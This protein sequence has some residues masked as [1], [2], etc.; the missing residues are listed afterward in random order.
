MRYYTT[1]EALEILEAEGITS[2]IQVLRRYLNKNSIPGAF[3]KSKKEGWSIPEEGLREFIVGKIGQDQMITKFIERSFIMK[4]DGLPQEYLEDVMVRLAHHSSAIEGNTISLPD[5][6]SILLYNTVPSQVNLREFYEVDN[7]R[8]AFDYLINQIQN[9]M[10][11]T[12]DSIKDIHELLTNKLRHDRGMFKPSDNAIRGANFKT[13]SPAETPY[14][15]NQWVGN[16]NYQ[17]DQA[18]NREQI[19]KTVGDFH[20]Q[21]ERIHPFSD[22]NGRTGRIVLNYSL[23]QNGIPPLIIEAKDKATYINILANQDVEKFVEFANPLIEQED[24][25]IKMFANK[26]LAKNPDIDIL[27]PVKNK[28]SNK[29]KKR[30]IER[31]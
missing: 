13:A 18:T 21:F 29:V 8:E 3:R 12:L 25:R 27:I 10:P 17:L 31:E 26:E 2:N 24:E 9:E 6:V 20:I 23:M 5:T 28:P 4:R 1:S 22:G 15:M 7:H 30:G 11:L 19:L 16:V 14:L